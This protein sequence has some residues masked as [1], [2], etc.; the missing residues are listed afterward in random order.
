MGISNPISKESYYAPGSSKRDGHVTGKSRCVAIFVENGSKIPAHIY[1]INTHPDE[2]SR[3]RVH[4]DFFAWGL[5]FGM[6]V[7][8]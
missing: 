8:F 7:A 6:E 3:G 1:I 4:V 5:T 2:N